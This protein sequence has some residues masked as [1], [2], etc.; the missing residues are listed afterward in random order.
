VKINITDEAL[1]ELNR[2]NIKNIRI[3]YHGQGCGGPVLS[4]A[5]GLPNMDEETIII[6]DFMFFL[7][8]ELID[9]YKTVDIDYSNADGFS[10]DAD[11]N[12]GCI[13]CNGCWLNTIYTNFEP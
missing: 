5:A 4:M 2:I 12:G 13:R 8:K 11:N 7:K 6:K 9:K 1:S 3:L 10:V